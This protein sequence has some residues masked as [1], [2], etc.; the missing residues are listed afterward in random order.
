VSAV[1]EDRWEVVKKVGLI[2]SYGRSGREATAE[3]NAGCSQ[4]LAIMLWS[5]M[6]PQ[7]QW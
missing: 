1:G 5:G 4:M 3:A 2:D 7:S 6:L